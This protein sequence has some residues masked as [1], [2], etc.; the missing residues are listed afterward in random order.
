M[1]MALL[2][3]AD[4][5]TTT[6]SGSITTG[7]VDSTGIWNRADNNTTTLT[8]TGVIT[9]N[10]AKTDGIYNVATKILP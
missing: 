4:S 3:V 9:V 1:V 10:G 7:G 8:S 5:N 2:T 6:V